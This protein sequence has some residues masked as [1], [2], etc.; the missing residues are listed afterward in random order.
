M[1]RFFELLRIAVGRQKCLSKTMSDAE[2][3]ALLAEAEKQSLIGVC[4]S[5]IEALP[6]EQLPPKILLLNWIGQA[7][8]QKSQYSIQCEA[9]QKV[10]HLLEEEGMEYRLM[11]GLGL[12][13]LYRSNSNPRLSP[14]QRTLGDFDIWVRGD[15]E[16]IIR[17]A[18]KYGKLGDVVYHHVDA[19]KIEGVEVELHFHPSSLKNLRANNRMQQWFDRRFSDSDVLMVGG[20]EIHV[21]SLA[22]NR[23]Y[24]LNHIYRHLLYEGVGLRQFLDYYFVLMA[25]HDLFSKMPNGQELW[26]REKEECRRLIRDFAME[27]FS[28]AITWALLCVFEPHALETGVVP[29]WVIGIP[30]E[31]RGRTLLKEM[32]KGGNF[33]MHD[34]DKKYYLS[35]PWIKRYYNRIRYDMKFLWQYP[36]EVLWRPL[37]FIW[38]RWE[39]IHLFNPSLPNK[40]I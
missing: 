37:W 3:E 9:L 23:I 25:S 19:G 5:A 26:E 29:D 32:L 28:N 4:F 15:K 2:W 24:V 13:D 39:N 6:K 27:H 35:D 30:D 11:K 38:E 12:A 21:T 10:V 16:H 8:Y 17:F 40:S 36:E 22:F 31:K 14:Q 20:K 1:T 34:R 18:E 7:E 33:G